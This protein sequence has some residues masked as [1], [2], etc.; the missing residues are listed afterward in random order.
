MRKYMGLNRRPEGKAG[1]I[2]FPYNEDK[3]KE[4]SNNLPT[5][6]DARLLGLVSKVKSELSFLL[7][8]T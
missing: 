8:I 5:E 4:I 3:L 6:Y 2:P 7:G 1:N